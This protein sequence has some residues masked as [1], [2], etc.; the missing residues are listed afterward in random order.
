MLTRTI[1][2]SSAKLRWDQRPLLVRWTI[3]ATAFLVTQP[4]IS[5]VHQIAIL[6][7]ALVLRWSASTP[8]LEW[9]VKTIVAEPIY[10][11]IALEMLG[12]INARG[13]AISGLVGGFLHDVWPQV[14]V[15]PGLVVDG[16]WVSAVV[17]SGSSVISRFLVLTGASGLLILLG[18]LLVSWGLEGGSVPRALATPSMVNGRV[19]FGLLLQARGVAAILSIGVTPTD[20]ENM[21]LAQIGTKLLVTSPQSYETTLLAL[22]GWLSFGLHLL[23]V[24]ADY[25]PALLFA[26]LLFVLLRMR[27][28]KRSLTG[29]DGL[30]ICPSRIKPLGLLPMVGMAAVVVLPFGMASTNFGYGASATTVNVVVSVGES[31][32]NIDPQVKSLSKVPEDNPVAPSPI[33]PPT[34]TPGPSVVSTT[35]SS[36]NFVYLVNG[37]RTWIRGVGYNVIYR[38]LPNERRARRYERDFSRMA[39]AGVNTILGWDSDQGYAHD[40]FDDLLLTRANKFGLGILMPFFL[41]P[42]GEYSNDSYRA[43]VTQDVIAFVRRFK[44]QPAIRMWAIGNEVMHGMEA[45]MVLRGKSPK[46]T[47]TAFAD[48]YLKLVDEVRKEDPNHPVIYRTAED[49][50]LGAF[51]A[52]RAKSV[53]PRPWLVFGMNVF[54]SRLKTILTNWERH[55]FGNPLLISEFAP[56]GLSQQDRPRGF[57]RMWR[58]IRSYSCS[59]IGGIVYVWTTAGPEPV[60]RVFG[61]VDGDGKAVDGSLDAI[62]SEFRQARNLTGTCG[63]PLQS[64]Q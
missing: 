42:N 24:V 63:P 8:L 37:K 64:S 50:F 15:D 29:L 47:P 52:V 18:V 3:I 28:S 56:T 31:A 20:L 48:F 41:D 13:L 38:D 7:A 27:G 55:G 21:G 34:P 60:D 10:S 19:L 54:S 32:A 17:A 40:K 57:V 51:K 33:Q 44:R 2:R 25:V 26:H 1:G 62:A 22:G 53:E 9:P 14:F 35:G 49:G 45:M 23:A 61:L 16:F 58:A 59:V 46:S 30:S 4:L 39:D 43:R 36:N 12:N 11:R 6:L 5:L